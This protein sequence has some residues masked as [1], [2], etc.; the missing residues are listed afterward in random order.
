M[1]FN[2]LARELALPVNE[3]AEKVKDIIPNANGGTEIDEQQEENI[4]ALVTGN[5]KA[6]SPQPASESRDRTSAVLETEEPSD[7]ELGI[8]ALRGIVQEFDRRLRGVTIA[9]E[10]I[11]RRASE[12]IYPE[13]PVA[14][15]LTEV[16][17]LLKSTGIPYEA[18]HPAL[19]TS[20]N[21]ESSG[22][23]LPSSV[24]GILGN[25]YPAELENLDR[26]LPAQ[27]EVSRPQLFAGQ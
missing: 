11:N 16:V 10:W 24:R 21:P 18:P 8:A 25:L 2:K 12:G 14:A 23:S 13:H 26:D 5:G 1:K 4:R 27:L 17:Y 15:K 7:E 22:I 20:G 6:R 19:K 9:Q 3:L